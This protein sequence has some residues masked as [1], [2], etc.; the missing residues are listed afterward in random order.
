MGEAASI[1]LDTNGA[2][3]RSAYAQAHADRLRQDWY[4]A[5]RE[6]FAKYQSELA[7]RQWTQDRLKAELSYLEQLQRDLDSFRSGGGGKKNAEGAKSEL[8]EVVEEVNRLRIEKSKRLSESQDR[9]VR[10]MD[11]TT[12][13]WSAPP[14]ALATAETLAAD[15]SS[16]SAYLRSDP[17]ALRDQLQLRLADSRFVGLQAG[18]ETEGQRRSAGIALSTALANRV[19][20]PHAVAQQV[21]AETMGVPL[22]DLDPVA[23][24][25]EKKK[26]AD[27][28]LAKAYSG[29]G[30][31]NKGIAEGEALLA[32][33]LGG[34]TA[35]EKQK[36][37]QAL[38]EATEYLA[39]PEWRKIRA[40]LDDGKLEAGE[41][42]GDRTNG[43]QTI[44]PEEVQR[45]ERVKG[46][47]AE[48]GLRDHVADPEYFDTLFLDRFGEMNRSRG[49]ID[50]LRT[51]LDAAS[52]TA[53]TVEDVRQRTAEI[54][55]PHRRERGSEDR[56]MA[57]ER[58]NKGDLGKAVASM[59]DQ[60]RATLAAGKEALKLVG[61]PNWKTSP[62][63]EMRLAQQV[64]GMMQSGALKPAE[65]YGRVA[66]LA[67]GDNAKRD[68]IYARVL[69][70]EAETKRG[71]QYPS[72]PSVW[73]RIAKQDEDK[74]RKRKMR[75]RTW[76]WL[77]EGADASAKDPADVGS[78]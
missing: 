8:M 53:P 3:Y 60:Q 70:F 46:L 73:D 43:D 16:N 4:Y 23:F 28:A 15:L 74:E 19:G 20:V 38:A 57:A 11:Q 72:T 68:A 37:A 50:E 10:L 69:A 65:V 12:Q 44:T 78:F 71:E 54:Y 5:E 7:E 31:L 52:P 42:T 51:K 61:D 27:D 40:A 76:S 64:R 1:P 48:N 63:E 14:S 9:V 25:F 58:Q 6:L 62:D 49:R 36:K 33:R 55:A 30:D 56:A 34:S 26:A 24:N 67:A 75:D 35:A 77:V 66:E 22:D 39:S 18:L 29:I 47:I 59:S 32:D 41:V 45:Y 13:A 21:V 17:Q 2:R